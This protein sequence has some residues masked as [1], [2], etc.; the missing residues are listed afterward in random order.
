[1]RGAAR[2][3]F[4]QGYTHPD[5][6][7]LRS[8][9]EGAPCFVCGFPA[10]GVGRNCPG[11][12]PKGAFSENFNDDN[13]LPTAGV[14]MCGPCFGIGKMAG[15]GD[16]SPVNITR[17]PRG[18]PGWLLA[19]GA[20]TPLRAGVAGVID[21]ARLTRRQAEFAVIVGWQ[22]YKVSAHHWI[23][24]PVAY[25][26]P[27]WPALFMDKDGGPRLVWVKDRFVGEVLDVLTGD[28]FGEETPVAVLSKPFFG[29]A[30][31]RK[32]AEV[33]ATITALRP[34]IGRAGA[35]EGQLVAKVL[36]CEPKRAP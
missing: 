14:T 12:N 11:G 20:I 36:F 29:Q 2:L 17:G 4:P 5:L 22:N 13:R 18:C 19:D 28:G 34:L 24:A 8:G 26:A 31:Q 25:P 30:S 10:E 27:T 23:S 6:L 7:P 15:K 9:Q 1:M 21:L 32:A 16:E 3:A 33:A 35:D